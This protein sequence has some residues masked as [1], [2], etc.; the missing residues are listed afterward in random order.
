MLTTIAF[1]ACVGR[2]EAETLEIQTTEINSNALN[3]LK[4]RLCME[5]SGAGIFAAFQP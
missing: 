5:I 2:I 3:G 1:C 4:D